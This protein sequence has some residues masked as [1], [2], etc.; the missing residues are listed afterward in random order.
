MFSLPFSRCR[1]FLFLA[2]FVSFTKKNHCIESFN[3]LHFKHNQKQSKPINKK[4]TLDICTSLHST[5]MNREQ[6][7]T[8]KTTISSSNHDIAD[9][10]PAK[11]ED[12]KSAMYST[13]SYMM[14]I[15]CL[16]MMVIFMPEYC[17]GIL[18][19]FLAFSYVVVFVLHTL[20]SHSF[21]SRLFSKFTTTFSQTRTRT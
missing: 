12:E 7:R 17:H 13:V 10:N 9:S 1:F 4:K 8:T 3:I 2:P 20:L 5:T 16:V 19:A 15:C 18:K 11:S 14:K 6:Q 21:D